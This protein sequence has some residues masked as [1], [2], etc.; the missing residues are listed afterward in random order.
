[1][2]LRDWLRF[3]V[4][5]DFRRPIHRSDDETQ[6]EQTTFGPM[7]FVVP[8]GSVAHLHIPPGVHPRFPDGYDGEV[9]VE[10]DIPLTPQET[11]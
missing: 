6:P 2:R 4:D 11:P 1:M 9:T 5:L 7:Q 3:L 10:S 8:P